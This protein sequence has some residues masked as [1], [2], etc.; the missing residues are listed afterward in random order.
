MAAEWQQFVVVVV[1]AAA[2]A[3][4]AAAVVVVAAEVV[5]GKPEAGVVAAEAV[6]EVVVAPEFEQWSEIKIYNYMI[7]CSKNNIRYVDIIDVKIDFNLYIC[8]TYLL[9]LRCWG[10]GIFSMKFSLVLSKLILGR[11]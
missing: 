4:V 6:V 3:A 11:S 8:K 5:A 9:V 1:V 10:C 7:K 2:V